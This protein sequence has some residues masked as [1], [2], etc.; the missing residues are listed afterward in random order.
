MDEGAE[1]DPDVLAEEERMKDLLQHRSG[2][3][4]AGGRPRAAGLLRRRACQRRVARSSSPR[5]DVQSLPA[6]HAGSGGALALQADSTNAVEVFGLQKVFSSG[7]CGG[8]CW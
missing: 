7:A 3:R 2:V 6:A 1:R 8:R 4:A 5:G